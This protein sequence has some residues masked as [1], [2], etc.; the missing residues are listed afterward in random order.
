M[1][2]ETTPEIRIDASFSRICFPLPADE[3][4]LLER[5]I[6]THGCREPL[7][8]WQQTGILLDGHHRKRICEAM[9]RSEPELVEL[10]EELW[11]FIVYATTSVDA[12]GVLHFHGDL[13]GHDEALRVALE[14]VAD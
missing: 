11:V 4:E 1:T 3:F 12:D 14:H 2:A 8:V 10:D 7:V 13:Y 6:L 5:S 9:V